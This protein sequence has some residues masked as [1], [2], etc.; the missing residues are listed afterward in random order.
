MRPSPAA[1][2]SRTSAN[3][4]TLVL[5][6]GL[7]VVGE[8]FVPGERVTVLVKSL[9]GA[10]QTELDQD[11]GFRLEIEAGALWI[12]ATGDRGSRAELVLPRPSRLH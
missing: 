8:G 3:V 2:R 1:A 5:E 7:V 6:A 12:S 4:P 10:H 9:H 11:G